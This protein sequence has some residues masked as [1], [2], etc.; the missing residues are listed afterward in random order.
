MGSRDQVKTVFV[1]SG[2][3]NLGAVQV[4]MLKALLESGIEPD[5]VVAT[6]IGALNGAFL[7]GHRDVA[8]VEALAELWTSVRRC[9]VFPLSLGSLARSVLAGRPF[10][11]ESQGL[12]DLLAGAELGFGRLEDA[13][14]PLWVVATDL[15]TGQAVILDEGDTITGV[16]ASSAIPGLFPSIE[17]N[18]RTLVDGGIVAN[19]PI[20]QAELLDPMEIYVLPTMPDRISGF[21]GNPIVMIQRAVALAI[22]PAERRAIAAAASRRAVWVLPV[23]DAAGRLSIFDFGATRRLIDDAH[24]LARLW[25]E[26][27]G[28]PEAAMYRNPPVRGLQ[29][30]PV[31]AYSEAMA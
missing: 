16:L 15:E 23:P 5:A 21:H 30:L 10:V 2:G 27:R 26:R 3:G 11:F 28:A 18:G 24:D 7:V 14:I 6:S 9:D 17:N 19:T 12:R 20:V 1:L 25:L 4:G 22:R 31:A 29:A 13:P 8:G